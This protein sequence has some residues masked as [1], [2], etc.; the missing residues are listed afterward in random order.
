MFTLIPVC[1]ML[2]YAWSEVPEEGILLGLHGARAIAD[3]L[4]GHTLVCPARLHLL[5]FCRIA[6]GAGDRKTPCRLA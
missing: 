6:L 3:V 5:Y 4:T 2:A 1:L